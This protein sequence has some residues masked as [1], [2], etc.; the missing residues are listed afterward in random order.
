MY[1][2]PVQIQSSP[3]KC[4]ILADLTDTVTA[5]FRSVSLHSGLTINPV[6]EGAHWTASQRVERCINT[7]TY[8]AWSS[9]LCIACTHRLTISSYKCWAERGLCISGATESNPG[10]LMGRDNVSYV[11]SIR[12]ITHRPQH[13]SHYSSNCIKILLNLA[14]HTTSLHPTTEQLAPTDTFS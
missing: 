7:G 14:P 3:D 5:A 4:A 12:S 9:H 8:M 13:D 11:I 2:T 10:G 1:E 6:R